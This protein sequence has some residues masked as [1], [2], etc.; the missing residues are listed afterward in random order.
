MKKTLQKL[1]DTFIAGIIFLLPLLLLIVLLTKV[2]Q[3]LTGFT[4]KIAS[5]FGLKSFI[6]VSGGTIVSAF[7]IIIL[8]I[9]CGYMVRISFFKSISTWIDKKMMKNIPGYSVYREMALSKLE[10][11]EEVIPYKS[12]AWI[13][14]GN[15]QQPGFL[16]ETMPDGK[17][18]IFIPTAG[19]IKEGAVFTVAPTE[20][21]LCTD[22]DIKA[23]RAA[24]NS[25]GA[26]LSKF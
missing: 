15:K 5:W 16:M 2:F 22:T 7:S 3:F 12:A 25:M 14:V 11:K 20:V 9:I 21:Q 24:I 1:R 4:A 26:G 23:F 8:C 19:N 13:N 18:V 17:L 6:G 10:D